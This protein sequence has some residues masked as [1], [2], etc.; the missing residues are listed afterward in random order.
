M[1]TRLGNRKDYDHRIDFSDFKSILEFDR[2]KMTVTLEPGVNMGQVTDLL[3]PE[4]LALMVQVE[5]E[6]LA[7]GG[8][9][10]EIINEIC[11]AENRIIHTFSCS[12]GLTSQIRY[13]RIFT[14]YGEHRI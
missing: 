12:S 2:E 3:G 11:I 8:L 5:M 6:S 7:I 1:S 9:V 13:F 4:N 14:I 10:M